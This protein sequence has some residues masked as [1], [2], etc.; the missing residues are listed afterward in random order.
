M[1]RARDIQDNLGDGLQELIDSAEALLEEL[2]DAKDPAVETLRAKLRRTV[3]SAS[4]RLQSFRPDMSELTSQTVQSTMSFV[5]RDP[6]RAI[7]LGALAVVAL[8]ILAHASGDE[9]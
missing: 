8:G 3:K 2:R 1:R 5:R 9:D 6:W 7:A 4:S